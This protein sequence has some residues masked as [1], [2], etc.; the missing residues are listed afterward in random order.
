MKKVIVLSTVLGLGALGMACGDT[1][2]NVNVNATK[3]ANAVV[4]NAMT[5]APVTT[6]A[7][8]NTMAPANMN[9][10]STMKPAMNAN[11]NMKP[12]NAMTPMS[13]RRP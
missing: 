10:N 1:G 9:T 8:T 13:T 11:S 2:T 5:P 4:V 12:A 6:P 7:T 3:P